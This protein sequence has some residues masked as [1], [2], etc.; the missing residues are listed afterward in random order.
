M[1]FEKEQIFNVDLL[2][3]LFDKTFKYN[4]EN[5]ISREMLEKQ[6]PLS[7]CQ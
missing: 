6:I 2:Y 7:M 4:R 3:A 5:H 1:V